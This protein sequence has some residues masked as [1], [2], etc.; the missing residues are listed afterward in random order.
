[1]N[2]HMITDSEFSNLTVPQRFFEYAIAY[3]NAAS[4]LCATMAEDKK[5]RTWPNANVVLMLAAHSTELFLKG[6]ILTREPLANI[7]HHFLD[8]LG[9]EYKRL[10]FES[11]FDWEIPF[12]T[13][14]GDLSE[15]EIQTM[16]KTAPVPSMLYRYPVSKGGKEWNSAFGFEAHSFTGILDQLESDFQRIMAHIAQPSV[17]A[18]ARRRR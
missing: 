14:W 16:R 17:P 4:A 6:A 12:R 11:H 15:A 8:A 10:F 5:L 1:M 3:R 9:V 2:W 13:E 7:E 18:A